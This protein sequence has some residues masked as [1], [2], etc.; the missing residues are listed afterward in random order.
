[1]GNHHLYRFLFSRETEEQFRTCF[2]R[3]H[4]GSASSGGALPNKTLECAFVFLP[5]THTHF[6]TF[7][8]SG[9]NA[10]GLISP[11]VRLAQ[12]DLDRPSTP[13]HLVSSPPTAPSSSSPAEPP[14]PTAARRTTRPLS[15]EGAPQLLHR[16]LQ[17]DTHLLRD[18][19]KRR[20]RADKAIPSFV[21]KTPLYPRPTPIHP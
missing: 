4:S 16:C 12:A 3:K 17:P 20:R 2:F 5:H 10:A 9:L 21:S 11:A 8:P 6:L 7:T 15:A 18:W 1:M 14:P 13:P 19:N